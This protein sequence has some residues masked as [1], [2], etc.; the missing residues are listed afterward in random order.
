VVPLI[1][2]DSTH[3]FDTAMD[4]AIKLINVTVISMANVE[5]SGVTVPFGMGPILMRLEKN[6]NFPVPIEQ[7]I[8]FAHQKL[9]E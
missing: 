3:R 6:R 5:Y 1:N 9:A 8:S 2:S 4:Q 7:L